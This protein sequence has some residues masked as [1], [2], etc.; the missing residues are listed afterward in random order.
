MLTGVKNSVSYLQQMTEWLLWVL[1]VVVISYAVFATM[2]T[3]PTLLMKLYSGTNTNVTLTHLDVARPVAKSYL[4]AY[5]FGAG[6]AKLGQVL[7]GK[8]NAAKGK[9][10]KIDFAKSIKGLEELKNKISRVFNQTKAA[11]DAWIPGLDGR[12]V[13]CSSD[14]QS[15]NY[16]LQSAEGITCKAA[17][18]YQ[19]EHIKKE[20][21]RAEPRLFYHDE[22][23]WCVHPDDAVRVGEI[24]KESFAE[25]PKMF[26]V[27]CMD[28]GDPMFGHSYAAVH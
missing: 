26:G 24:L 25:G 23:A 21:L 28:G 7:T 4:Y 27:T 11:G 15:L 2:L 10:S 3:I 17:I 14:H 12:P 8:A 6:D 5:L 20:G 13:F 16:L 1:T 18:S 9:K 19:M 22:S